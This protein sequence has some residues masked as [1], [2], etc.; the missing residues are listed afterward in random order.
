METAYL[1]NQEKQY[2]RLEHWCGPLP[3]LTGTAPQHKVAGH[4]M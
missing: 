3:G 4:L 2:K 1:E